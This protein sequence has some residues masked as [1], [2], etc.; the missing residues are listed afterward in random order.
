MSPLRP[1]LSQMCSALT[2]E[3]G[4]AGGVPRTQT[5]GP[6][7]GNGSAIIVTMSRCPLCPPESQLPLLSVLLAPLPHPVV[8]PSFR[9]RH[10]LPNL[11]SL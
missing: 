5:W 9:P 1:R 10:P 3:T 11:T 7:A 8:C 2:Q 4:G 6:G